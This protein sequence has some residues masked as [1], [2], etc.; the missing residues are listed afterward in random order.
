MDWE[1]YDL[2]TRI[3]YDRLYAI[4]LERHKQGFTKWNE[5]SSAV[6]Y[7]I[8]RDID[9]EILKDLFNWAKKEKGK[10]L[11]YK[12]NKKRKFKKW[13]VTKQLNKIN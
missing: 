6:I 2:E 3:E 9:K 5:V 12:H 4:D 7:E 1:A 11:R 10:R 8:R 13:P